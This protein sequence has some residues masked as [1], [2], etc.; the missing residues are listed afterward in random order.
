MVLVRDRNVPP[1][2]RNNPQTVEVGGTQCLESGVEQQ[3]DTKDLGVDGTGGV[4]F[5]VYGISRG[6]DGRWSSE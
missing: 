5:Q 3:K 1:T 4:G 2:L 6:N